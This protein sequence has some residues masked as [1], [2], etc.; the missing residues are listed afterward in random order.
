[1]SEKLFR[2]LYMCPKQYS[3]IYVAHEQHYAISKVKLCKAVKHSITCI[4]NQTLWFRSKY[5]SLEWELLLSK[6]SD[7]TVAIHQLPC[8][9]HAELY[10]TV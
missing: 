9:I 5:N 8:Y 10:K 6:W 7:Y 4:Y 1:M 3:I 2:T